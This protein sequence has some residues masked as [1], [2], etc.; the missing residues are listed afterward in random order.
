MRSP[1]SAAP[2]R[3]STRQSTRTDATDQNALKASG[4]STAVESKGPYLQSSAQIDEQTP[5]EGNPASTAQPSSPLAQATNTRLLADETVTLRSAEQDTDT[6]TWGARLD[7]LEASGAVPVSRRTRSRAAA[8]ASSTADI[9]AVMHAVQPSHTER[10]RAAARSSEDS[11]VKPSAGKRNVAPSLSARPTTR[12]G[13]AKANPSSQ[14]T[15]NSVHASTRSISE[16]KSRQRPSLQGASRLD[17]DEDPCPAAALPHSLCCGTTSYDKAGNGVHHGA[18]GPTE[19]VPARPH[20]DVPVPNNPKD[21][22]MHH[23][24]SSPRTLRPSAAANHVKAAQGKGREA[25]ER[26]LSRRGTSRGSSGKPQV[27]AEAV[28]DGGVSVGP[29]AAAARKSSKV[30]SEEV[31]R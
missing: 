9:P 3:A 27:K 22:S 31:Q 4:P 2:R 23:P 6:Q 14:D 25:E 19:A 28:E 24:H 26:I 21:A 18:S 15:L 20:E 1:R 10:L 11:L 5:A 29:P 16:G 8:Q 7:L 17:R 13:R 12:T 30:K